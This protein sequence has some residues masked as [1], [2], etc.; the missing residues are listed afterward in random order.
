MVS[1]T[2]SRKRLHDNGKYFVWNYWDPGVPW[3]TNRTAL[4]STGSACTRTAGTTRLI[5]TAIVA[6][7]EHGLVFTQEDM[8]RLIATN[9]D[10]MWNRQ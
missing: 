2:K 3:D 10:F 9:R 8:A 5:S 6:A 7:Y 1:V 4:S